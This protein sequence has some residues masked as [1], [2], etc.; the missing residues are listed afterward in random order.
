MEKDKLYVVELGCNSVPI[1]KENVKPNPVV[2]F[3]KFN[4]HCTVH[5]TVFSSKI[6][7]SQNH[8]KSM[9]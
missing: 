4:A 8:E 6:H 1:G 3:Y 2:L 7:V 5:G 9:R